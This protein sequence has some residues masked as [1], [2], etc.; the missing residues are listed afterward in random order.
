M[1]LTE[2]FD[3]VPIAEGLNLYFCPTDRFKAVSV[4]V[5]IHL[6]LNENVTAN[7]LLSSILPRGCKK[8]VNMRKIS[9]FLESLY[10]SSF[11]S[12]V[13]KIGERHLLEFGFR[14]LADRFLPK[15]GNHLKQGLIFLKR[16]ISEPLVKNNGF[17]PEYVAQEKENLRKEISGLKDDKMEYARQRFIEVMCPDE[18]YRFYDCGRIEDIDSVTPQSLLKRLHY[19]IQKAPIDIFVYGHFSPAGI[20]K[21]V[22]NSFNIKRELPVQNVPATI[23]NKK[24][25]EEKVFREEMAD[26][27]QA[28]LLMGYR[29]YTTWSDED[30]F[31]LMV[32]NG[33]L[34]AYPHSKLFT[35]VREKA[36]LAYYA[37]SALERTKG[38]MFIHSGILPDKFELAVK[39]IKEQVDQVRQGDFTDEEIANT[40]KAITDRLQSLRD[41]PGALVGFTLEHS[42][43]NR[44]DSLEVIEQKINSVAKEDI[45][46]MAEKIKLDTIYFLSAG[47]Q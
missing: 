24:V 4:N 19:I 17:Y 18:P 10:G 6:P 38:L 32:F 30:V 12:D 29:T 27:Q 2:K 21:M 33:V 35:N 20:K 25:G 14:G 45:I 40:K 3:K 5:F 42:I 22:R 37:S 46:R 16:I 41:S 1:P 13:N 39:I 9:T 34:G 44:H 43:N 8:Y 47:K 26:A 7:S 15:K 23:V 36:G 28:K 31:P 11:S